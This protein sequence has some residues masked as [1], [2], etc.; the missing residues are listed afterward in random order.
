MHVGCLEAESGSFWDGGQRLELRAVSIALV[1]HGLVVGPSNPTLSRRDG[2]A[3]ARHVQSGQ[4][5][6]GR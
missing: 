2:R 5:F 4:V 6:P 1:T 3:H